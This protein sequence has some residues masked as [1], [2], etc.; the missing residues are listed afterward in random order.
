[1]VYQSRKLADENKDNLSEATVSALTECI[2]KAEEKLG[3]VS[4][5]EELD[6]A[7]KELETI[8]H[9]AGKEVYSQAQQTDAPPPPDDDVID[10][11][12][13]DVG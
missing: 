1:M 12:Y 5:A 2:E 6:A 7:F 3:V 4:E 9:V 10:V 11:E 8:L 13:D